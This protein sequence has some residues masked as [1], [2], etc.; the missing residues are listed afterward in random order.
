LPVRPTGILPV[1]MVRSRA[2]MALR[3]MGRMPMPRR[4][5]EAAL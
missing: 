2:K 5:P 3:R 4:I 1:E